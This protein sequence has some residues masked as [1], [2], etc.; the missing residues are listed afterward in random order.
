MEFFVFISEQWVLVSVLLVLVYVFAIMERSK[1]GKPLTTHE[2]TRMLNADEAV[3]LDVRDAK[4]F[5]EGHIVGA[6]HIPFSKIKDNHAELN[7]HKQKVIVV[8]DKVGQHSGAVGRVLQ[9]NGFEV[10]RL[11][12]GMME[13]KNQKLPVVKGKA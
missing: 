9:Q 1:S 4:E 6:V 8:A 2:L 5:K 13:W 7:S 11:S 10:R 12:G 3:L